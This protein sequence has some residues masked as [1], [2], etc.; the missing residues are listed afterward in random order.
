MLALYTMVCL[1]STWESTWL[2]RGEVDDEVGGYVK[3][4]SVAQAW[5][6][7]PR[8]NDLNGL[9]FEIVSPGGEHGGLIDMAILAD[10]YSKAT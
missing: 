6:E 4:F 8:G 3:G 10:V 9:L 7:N 5:G 2:S 1:P